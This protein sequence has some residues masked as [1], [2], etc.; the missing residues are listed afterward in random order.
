MNEY[1]A[2]A[3]VTLRFAASSYGE[4]QGRRLMLSQGSDRVIEMAL[5][6]WGIVMD[7]EFENRVRLVEHGGPPPKPGKVSPPVDDDDL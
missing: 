2:T 7:V 6:K 1:Q 5:E 3:T 4:A